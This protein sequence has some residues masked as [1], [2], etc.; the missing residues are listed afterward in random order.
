V[1][2]SSNDITP[3]TSDWGT[4]LIFM[5]ELTFIKYRTADRIDSDKSVVR[6]R[7]S[8]F[9]PNRKMVWSSGMPLGLFK[10]A[11][12]FTLTPMDGGKTSVTVEEIFT[13]LLLPLIGRT[14]PDLQPSFN[15]FV[16]GLKQR[17]ESM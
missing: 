17:A 3:M 1:T 13:G 14:I 16:E 6:D 15:N 11:R 9:E 4:W 2:K 10:G 7:V 8:V 12:T 5:K